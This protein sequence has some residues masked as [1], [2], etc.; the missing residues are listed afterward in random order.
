MAKIN[1]G[2]ALYDAPFVIALGPGFTAGH[3]CH[4]VIETNRGHD[5]GRAIYTG[6]AEPNTGVPGTIQGMSHTRVLRAPI[7][8]RI[9]PLAQIGD[10][11]QVEQ[12]IATIQGES[13]VAPFAGVLR[14][15]IHPSVNVTKNMKIGD[16]DPRA[17]QEH[18]FTISD[19]AFAIGGGVL[20]A[21]MASVPVRS[22]FFRVTDENPSGI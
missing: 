1:L 4:V 14:G 22:V 21:V 5:L 6:C 17:N 9:E 11:I 19:K 3:D 16:L 20:E 13:I 15:L 10:I 12:T 7:D 8:G 18:C 2:T